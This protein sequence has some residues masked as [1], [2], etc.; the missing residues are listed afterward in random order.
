M[1]AD[2]RLRVIFK[3][4]HVRDDADW[5]GSG[6]WYFRATVNNTPVGDTSFTF[7]A[8]QDRYIRLPAS[9]WYAIEP[10]GDRRDV[11]V[12]F[13]AI[14][15]DV[16]VDDDLGS[17]EKTLSYP[18]RQFNYR[19][20]HSTE[21][22]ILDWDVELSVQGRFGRHPPNTVFA[23]RQHSGTVSYNTVSGT[24]GMARLEICPVRPTPP[25]GSLPR[26]PTLLPSAAALPPERNDAHA[27]IVTAGHV[28]IL[29]PENIMPNPPVIPILTPPTAEWEPGNPPRANSES[30]ARIEFSYYHPANLNF[31]DADP[32]LEWSFRS[33]SG[34]AAVGFAGPSQGRKV[35]VYGTSA[36]EV[37]L[38]IRF[39]GA[40]FAT[41]RA[42]VQS[43]R[44]IRYRAN[45]LNGPNAASRPRSTP[46][47]VRDHIEVA[48]R[49]LRQM[50]LML[51]PDRNR[52]LRHNARR[53]GI[54]GIFRISVPA[55]R[56]RNLGTLAAF[57]W[58]TRR[59]ARANVAHPNGPI[60]NIAYVHSAHR[61]GHAPPQPI[62]GAATDFP[63]NGPGAAANSIFDTDT[64][65]AP[66]AG[67]DP[68]SPTT[69]WYRAAGHGAG[70]PPD[71]DPDPAGTEMGLVGPFQ[72]PGPPNV[73]NLFAFL[74]SDA[75]PVNPATAPGM[76]HFGRTIAH[77]LGHVL[78]LRHRTGAGDDGLQYPEHENVMC[79]GEPATVG[80]DF[81]IIQARAASRGPLVTP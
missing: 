35:L 48:N 43:I 61:P 10:V 33:L 70:V 59:N 57:R 77:E 15:R 6:E 78:N 55:N 50:G 18:Y 17:V 58:A 71:L 34:G 47:N 46:E 80:Q 4:V 38:E 54:D 29:V 45:I 26:R 76:M 44:C 27:D 20:R 51:I 11:I 2:E 53:T 30:A 3:R 21:Y 31:T 65:N 23:T 56:T 52:P 81:D 68:P 16:T 79:Q 73:S 22:F 75:T 9:Q 66:A 74:I 72:R 36:G 5:I 24:G 42:L 12:R 19:G 60:L 63:A 14:D 28:P 13:Q 62:W 49:F 1:S 64:G 40:L 67:T 41:Y 8:V 7:N 25:D 32:R 69:S 37:L 39:Q